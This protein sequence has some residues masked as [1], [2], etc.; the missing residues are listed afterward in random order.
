MPVEATGPGGVRRGVRLAATPGGAAQGRRDSRPIDPA[1]A[2]PYHH[3]GPQ[4][5]LGEPAGGRGSPNPRGYRIPSHGPRRRHHLSRTGPDRRLSDHGPARM[6]AR[7]GRLR[8][9]HRADVDRYVVGFWNSG[10]PYSEMHGRMGGRG[11]NRRDRR[12]Y[13][14]MGYIARFRAERL[15][16]PAVFPVHC[17]LRPFE[18][19]DFDGAIGLRRFMGGGSGASG[20]ALWP[21]IRSRDRE[22][23]T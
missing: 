15:D 1:G 17:S 20:R 18:A 13:Q 8:A 14:P 12:A 4:R 3:H 21:R 6:E 11:Q 23:S 9:G 5:P 7:R 2:P 10:R 16:G 22:D 19:R